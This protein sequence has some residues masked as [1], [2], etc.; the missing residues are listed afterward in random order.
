MDF[1]NDSI[2]GGN[3][4]VLGQ[5]KPSAAPRDKSGVAGIDSF[6]SP[7]SGDAFIGE[8][9]MVFSGSVDDNFTTPPTVFVATARIPPNSK[10]Q[11]VS[12]SGRISMGSAVADKIAVLLV[13]VE[14]VETGVIKTSSIDIPNIDRGNM[15]LFSD[16]IRG[17]EVSNNTIK[18]SVERNAQTG[19]DNAN[20]ASVTLHNLQIGTDN[21]SVSGKSQSNSFSYSE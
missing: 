10:S 4:G 6:I 18:V 19:T 13:T 16:V 11:K 12:V 7:A 17:A 3:F 9:G 21:T 8:E 2:L 1:N 5:T 15:I 14:C 20:F